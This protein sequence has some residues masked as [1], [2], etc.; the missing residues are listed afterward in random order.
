[1]KYCTACGKQISLAATFC[2]HCGSRQLSLQ[3]PAVQSIPHKV[4]EF[5]LPNLAAYNL[6]PAMASELPQIG[7]MTMLNMLWCGL[8]NKVIGDKKG[9]TFMLLNI[10]ILV[11]SF[12]LAFIPSLAFLIYCG[13]HGWQHIVSQRTPSAGNGQG[14]AKVNK[15][16]AEKEAS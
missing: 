14:Q 6:K 3:Q 13:I 1:M 4:S 15:L 11:A 2:E 7:L 5:K 16:P 9:G 8:G 10:P 12:F